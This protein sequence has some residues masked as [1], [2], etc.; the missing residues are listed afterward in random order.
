[1]DLPA[2]A[3]KVK[4]QGPGIE[5]GNSVAESTYF[6][7]LTEGKIFTSWYIPPNMFLETCIKAVLGNL[8]KS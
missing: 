6:D 5:P 8:R 1:V 2:D 4:V 3:S 7:V